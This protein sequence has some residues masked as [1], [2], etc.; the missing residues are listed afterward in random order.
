[1]YSP[2]WKVGSMEEP[3]TLKFWRATRTSKKIA[4]VRIAVSTISRSRDLDREAGIVAPSSV[5]GQTNLACDRLHVSAVFSR[6][7]RLPVARLP[8]SEELCEGRAEPGFLAFWRAQGRRHGARRRQIW[9]G[10]A[11]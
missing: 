7:A 3:S 4:M 6:S 8:E 11:V 1:M 5:M 9:T 2:E 10:E